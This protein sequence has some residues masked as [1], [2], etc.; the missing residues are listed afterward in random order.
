[1][2]LRLCPALAHLNPLTNATGNFYCIVALPVW[3]VAPGPF[4]QKTI[5]LY[6][7]TFDIQYNLVPYLQR[8]KSPGNCVLL[9]HDAGVVATAI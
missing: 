2:T 5:S 6:Q 9:L 8:R 4:T 3:E 1:M 7:M